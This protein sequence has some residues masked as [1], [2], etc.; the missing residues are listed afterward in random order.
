M[1]AKIFQINNEDVGKRVDVYLTSAL[2]L[3]RSHIKKLCDEGNLTVNGKVSKSNKLL[4]ENDVVAIAQPQMKN[5]DI[6]PENIPLDVL[7]EDDDYKNIGLNDKVLEHNKEVSNIK[8]IKKQYGFF[9]CYYG[10]DTSKLEYILWES[11]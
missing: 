8:S 9:T 2:G 5:L 7:Y 4:K 1:E 11:E 6:E 10:L 3:T